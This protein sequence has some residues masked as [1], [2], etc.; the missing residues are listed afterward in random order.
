MPEELTVR[1]ST[2]ALK[3]ASADLSKKS[4]DLKNAFGEMTEA[5]NRTNGY[6]LGE[7]GEAHREVYHQL[8]PRQE[9]ALKRLQEQVDNLSK[10]AGI[11]EETE[12]EVKELDLSL[13]DDVIM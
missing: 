12:Q 4:G 10:I 13:P 3:Q 9:E 11:W 8:I 6:W 1:I 2:E 5:M 7:A